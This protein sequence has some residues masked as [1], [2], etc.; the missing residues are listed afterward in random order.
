MSEDKKILCACNGLECEGICR[1]NHLHHKRDWAIPKDRCPAAYCKE[2][3]NAR[4]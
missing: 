2:N 4:R 3:K 1:Q